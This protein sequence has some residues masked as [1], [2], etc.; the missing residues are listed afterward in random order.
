MNRSYRLQHTV[1][2]R[3]DFSTIIDTVDMAARRT[4]QNDAK[5]N[6]NKSKEMLISFIQD[7]EFRS[8][9]PRLIIDGNEIGNVQYAKLL[10]RDHNF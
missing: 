4:L 9:V 1:N 6:S 8:T 7:R 5:I 2:D 10:S 3:G